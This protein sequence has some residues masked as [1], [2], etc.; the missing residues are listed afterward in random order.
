MHNGAPYAISGVVVFVACD[1]YPAERVLSTLL[2]GEVWT[3]K[4]AYRRREVVFGELTS[5][6]DVRFTDVYGKHWKRS[7]NDLEPLASP[8]RIC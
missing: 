4:E 1:D 2:P 6:A 3:D 8:P 7:P 5:G